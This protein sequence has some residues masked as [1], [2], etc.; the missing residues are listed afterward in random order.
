MTDQRPEDDSE[1]LP[2]D[3]AGEGETAEDEVDDAS[4]D[5]FPASDPPSFTSSTATRDAKTDSDSGDA[6]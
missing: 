2:M 3:H 6:H 5:S 1:R 4:A